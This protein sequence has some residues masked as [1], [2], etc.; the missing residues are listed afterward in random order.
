MPDSLTAVYRL[1][2]FSSAWQAGMSL[3]KLVNSSYVV[4]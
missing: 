2:P 1:L 4:V 3:E